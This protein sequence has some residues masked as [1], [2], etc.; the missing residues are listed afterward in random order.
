MVPMWTRAW[1]FANVYAYATIDIVF[2]ILWFALSIAVAVWE[3]QSTTGAKQSSD[4][5]GD[6]RVVSYFAHGSET[7]RDTARAAAAFGF[8]IFILL[9]GT[10]GLSIQQIM[11]Y[12]RTGIKPGRPAADHQRIDLADPDKDTWSANVDDLGSQQVDDRGDGYGHG[13]QSAYGQVPQHDE[14]DRHG[15]LHHNRTSSYS[16][17]DNVSLHSR[18]HYGPREI[19]SLQSFETLDTMFSHGQQ[20]DNYTPPNA[21]GANERPPPSEHSVSFPPGDYHRLSRGE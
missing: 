11:Q 12:K 14:D 13:S 17:N 15:L 20:P 8:L 10:S 16:M 4:G 9:G 6:T 2:A 18:S 5:K 7:R 19:L 21:L 3:S 1:R